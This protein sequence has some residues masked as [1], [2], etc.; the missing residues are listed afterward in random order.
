MD[1]E[2]GKI[3]GGPPVRD[4]LDYRGWGLTGVRKT[5]ILLIP[6]QKKLRLLQGPKG[7]IIHRRN[8]EVSSP[9]DLTE[10]TYLC[11]SDGLGGDRTR[12]PVDKKP[13]L[14]LSAKKQLVGSWL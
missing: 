14:Y 6:K 5:K 7:R 4:L 2:S 9:R 1:I 8:L 10:N 12:G 13:F 11:T 3:V